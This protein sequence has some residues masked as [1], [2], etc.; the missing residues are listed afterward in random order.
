[1][2]RKVRVE[3]YQSLKDV[4]VTFGRFT[5]ILGESNVGKSALLR[6]IKAVVEN[7]TG[8]DFL[9]TG[10]KVCRV[11]MSLDAGE[12]VI[13]V[14][15]EKRK[16]GT[17]YSLHT[18]AIEK[19]GKGV[20]VP[21]EIINA[22]KLER[23]EFAAGIKFSPNFHDQFSTPFLLE[24]TGGR[25]AKMLG[26]MS[27]VNLLY[28]AT[29]EANVRAKRNSQKAEDYAYALE[30]LRTALQGYEFIR[31]KG[32]ALQEAKKQL[33]TVEAEAKE[34][35]GMVKTASSY[36]TWIHMVDEAEGE[37]LSLA[38]IKEAEIPLARA[39]AG[40]PEIK[41]GKEVLVSWL[42]A[43]VAAKD[44][45]KVIQK[46]E[47]LAEV[48]FGT[49][50]EDADTVFLMRKTRD[51]WDNSRVAAQLCEQYVSEHR[52]AV[53]KSETALHALEK[54]LKVCPYCGQPL[55]K[56]GESCASAPSK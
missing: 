13:G 7:Q 31:T 23:I 42:K 49:I 5:V 47:P 40:M 43:A 17:Q 52:A 8:L 32:P 21:V 46:M 24:E 2:I 28:R 27:G 1:M 45:R 54:E 11:E 29:A 18:Q 56:K 50:E 20:G 38:P 34:L 36:Q 26:E 3:G 41:R 12:D 10:A 44:A 51:A 30:K 37:A 4:E 55:H 48:D 9:T 53:K 14:V 39:E 16:S 33:G 35:L 25:V 22:L 19:F 15:W 6:A